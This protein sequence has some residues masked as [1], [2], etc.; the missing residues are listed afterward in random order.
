MAR[1]PIAA[2][3]IYLQSIGK[4]AA[5]SWR[6]S[7]TGPSHSPVWSSICRVSGRE[8]GSGEGSQKH[9]AR[10]EAAKVALATLTAEAGGT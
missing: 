6:D 7:M 8:Y 4:S 1:D 5:L 9:L 3:N 2:L 10:G